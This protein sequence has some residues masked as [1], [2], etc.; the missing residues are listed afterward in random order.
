[1]MMKMEI[2]IV[3]VK[4]S[5]KDKIDSWLSLREKKKDFEYVLLPVNKYDG[6]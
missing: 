4:M 3:S 2:K 1:M 5:N 6:Q